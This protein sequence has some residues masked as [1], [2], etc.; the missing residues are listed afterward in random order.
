MRKIR[1]FFEITVIFIGIVFFP[2]CDFFADGEKDND[3]QANQE[4]ISAIRLTATQLSTQV[5]GICYL[6]FSAVPSSYSISPNWSFDDEIISIEKHANGIIIKGMKEGQSEIT[7]SYQNR[8]ATAIVTVSGYSENYVDTTEPYIYS[9]TTII[10]MQPNDSETI[11][12]SLYNGTAAD[13]NGYTWL[14]ENPAVASIS[15]TG[16][17]CRIS[18]LSQG[19]SRI[20]VTHSKSP[21]PYYIGIYVLDDFSKVTFITTK[22][23]ILKLNTAQGEKNISVILTNPKSENYSQDFSWKI[24]SGMEH[25]A[26]TTN[27]E[28]C[29]LT[30]V[31]AGMAY[32]RITHP[33]A[34]Y[35]LDITVRV[36]E[37]VENVYIDISPKTDTFILDGSSVNTGS[38]SATLE[39]ISE[40]KDYSNDDFYF[41]VSQ[42]EESFGNDPVI[43][44]QSFANKITFKGIRNGAAVISVG[45]PKAAKKKQ[46]LVIVENQTI[47][48]VDASCMLSTSQN[49]IKTKI[50][51]E[52]TKLLVSLKGG[53][54][55]DIGNFHWS[56]SQSPNDG[57]SDVIE[58]VTVDG[59]VSS[60]RM[61]EQSY[62][63]GTAYIK[64]LATGYAT[65]TVT[66]TKSYYPLEIL[67]KV[68]DEN[69]VLENQYYFTGSG[70]VR[71]LNSESYEYTASLRSAPESTKN[72]ISWKSD[73]PTL[74][75]NAN[76]ENAVLSSNASGNTISHITVNHPNAQAPKEV[77]VLTA[78]TQE[79]L[80]AMRA[81][82]SD[83]TYYTVNVESTVDLHVNSVGFTDGNGKELDFST[84]TAHV[85]WL[86]SD[87][88]IASV[89]KNTN[90]PL[91]AIVRGN[92]AGIAK[93]SIVYEDISASFTV[94]V[95]PKN[96]EIGQIEKTIYLTTTNNVVVLNSDESKNIRISAIGLSS[97][98]Y[99][100][101]QW[102]LS[103]E[104]IA[105]VAANGTNATVTGKAEGESIL[106]VSHPDCENTLKIHVRIGSEYVT[107]ANS[108]SA[109]K[110]RVTYIYTTTDTVA[111]LTNTPNY[112]LR[113]SLVNPMNID[114]GLS[115][116]NFTV[117]DTNV[118][119]IISSYSTGTCY[120]KPVGA[121]QTEITV[122]HPKS[123][124]PKKILVLVKNT[125]EELAEI[126]Y[127]TTNN[128]VVN[129]G[130]KTTQAVSVTLENA[131]E[132][133]IGGF[134]WTSE[135]ISI[136]SVAETTSGTALISGNKIGTTRIK[137]SHTNSEY[138][139]YI[140]VQVIDPVAAGTIPYIQVPNPILNLVESSS[141]TTLTAELMGGKESDAI[142]FSWQIYDGNELVD[143]YAQNGIAKIRAKKA[144][145]AIVRVSHPKAVYPQDIRIICEAASTADYSIGV[146]SGN[147]MS[148][149][150][151]AGDQTI[152]ATLVNG[153]SS[154][155]YNF[156]WSLDV[157]DVVDLTYSAN[158]AII[159]PLKEG[160]V[161]L[162]VSHPKSAYDQQIVIKVQQYNTF[163]F[164]V[165]SKTVIAGQSSFISMQ[166]P[167]SSEKT[168][169]SYY[170]DNEKVVG[171]SG[172][173]AVCQITGRSAETTTVH[174]NLISEKTGTVL[175]T[176][177]MLV[178]VT[179]A[180]ANL[181]YITDTSGNSST[182][183]MTLGTSKIITA[184]IIGDDITV[185]DS[186]ELVWNVADK[187]IL[188]LA[189]ADAA[190]NVAGQSA[191]IT[192][193]K[194]GETTL[195]VSHPKAPGSLTYHIIVPG[196]DTIEVSLDKNFV[197]LEKGKNTTVKATVSSKQSSDY[198]KLVWSISKFGGDE[199]ATI[200]G[201]S[202]EN[203]EI[204]GGQSVTIYAKKAGIVTLTCL[205]SESGEKAECQVQVTDPKS[206]LLKQQVIKVM[207]NQS[208]T[209]EYT[210]SPADARMDWLWTSSSVDADSVFDYIPHGHNAEGNGTVTVTGIKEGTAQLMGI[211][212]YGNKASI[213]VQV[214]WD[215]K[216][217]FTSSDKLTGTPGKQYMIEYVVNPPDANIDIE[218]GTFYNATY[219]HNPDAEGTGYITFIPTQEGSDTITVRAV[220]PATNSEIGTKNVKLDFKYDRLSPK[221]KLGNCDGK[222]SEYDGDI[223]IIG[224]GETVGLDCSFAETNALNSYISDVNFTPIDGAK[225]VKQT[226]T[227]GRGSPSMSITIT[228]TTPIDTM[229]YRIEKAYV[230]VYVHSTSEEKSIL[231]T[232]YSEDSRYSYG[233]KEIILP[234]ADYYQ[235]NDDADYTVAHKYIEYDGS[236]KQ[237]IRELRVWT[238]DD[239]DGYYYRL[240]DVR[241]TRKI[242]K[243]DLLN[244]KDDLYWY[245]ASTGDETFSLLSRSYSSI[246][247][248]YAVN[249]FLYCAADINIRE[250]FIGIKVLDSLN[251]NSW[252][253]KLDDSLV[254]KIYTEDEFKS[255]PWF[256]CPGTPAQRDVSSIVTYPVT[257]Q[258]NLG[259][260]RTINIPARIMTD[261]VSAVYETSTDISTVREESVG[262]ITVNLLHNGKPE[263]Y[264]IPVFR[265]I[266][267]C[268]KDYRP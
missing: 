186:R 181:T 180:V 220:N 37:I 73:S 193:A 236:D 260:G 101:I 46:V 70:I 22:D 14:I 78:D 196:Q 168:K 84:V 213:K 176:A 148:I 205:H 151:D 69:A 31:S 253:K 5:G 233:G 217:Q 255:I 34:E 121:G 172:T 76:G 35:P 94:T 115:G 98:K 244:W 11:H 238:I 61:A 179:P 136:A 42:D 187:N 159:T 261:N 65:I 29:V 13:I 6:G 165:V 45:H 56:I 93:I 221:V 248:P 33:D 105:T 204:R 63:Y 156:I 117:E 15:P 243:E 109:G 215:Y 54:S 191:Y 226:E 169:V 119:D 58:L 184:E 129:I 43:E 160:T 188:T 150:P 74:I 249:R 144:G 234:S 195:T 146:S 53:N 39:G 208:K 91:S 24:T 80:E 185:I 242:I 103:D 7:C 88:T 237:T 268:S 240:Q 49:F 200:N 251:Y 72:E 130:E 89:E 250:E 97:T 170:S 167:A 164:S 157:Y 112:E 162:T 110:N 171:I 107:G 125:A 177:D 108:E 3:S 218:P 241:I 85:Q 178:I 1:Y 137:V 82:Y 202:S 104:S 232:E 68:L 133:V 79:E 120:L 245:A 17:Y 210:V 192:A 12:V 267:N 201:G 38:F 41:D 32:V 114:D 247:S 71:F 52:E 147:I 87:P 30:P 206:L 59:S 90:W 55:E 155:K 111:I 99:P 92:K 252:T 197:N 163:G 161:T 106:T 183:S 266:H 175:A 143:L 222:W 27:S 142:D 262:Q 259:N 254:G 60:S 86:S 140:I 154:D 225:N 2:S 246:S 212:S 219:R 132:T 214:S 25:L 139:L 145:C 135:D 113:A 229:Q 64:P 118:V 263:S 158:T 174:A 258:G 20:K 116:F 77:L 66:N 16:Q 44:Y 47:D 153:T 131:T 264:T 28:N 8:S 235:D 102:Q 40:G 62:A 190:G 26:I 189:G 227:A 152:T 216:F 51:A 211:S 128:N 138:P 18:S 75:I 9:D 173:S 265:V 10:Q 209:F 194:S 149:R 19:F 257:N 228:D 100:A 48:A 95:F 182:F 199:I 83:K 141:W 127:L 21:Y 57:E 239:D 230:P 166:I 122:T 203:G 126:K 134:T 223:L 23:N 50:G 198:N 96:V 224:D 231:A 67:V 123:A 124:Y 207:P 36:V 4:N 256:Y 81:F